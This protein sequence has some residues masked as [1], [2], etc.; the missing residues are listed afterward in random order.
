MTTHA[1]VLAYAR[2]VVAANPAI[3]PD[4]LRDVLRARFLHGQDIFAV[5]GAVNNPLD[6][7]H[8]LA[9]IFRGIARLIAGDATGVQDIIEGVV[10]IVT[11]EQ[12]N[13]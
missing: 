8:G 10:R 2:R 9:S 5:V 7:L 13:A 11:E 4:A 3:A 12:A 1:E 6:W